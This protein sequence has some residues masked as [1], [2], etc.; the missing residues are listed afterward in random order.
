MICV[1]GLFPA[2]GARMGLHGV[3]Y[4]LAR[5]A[6]TPIASILDGRASDGAGPSGWPNPATEGV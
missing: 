6:G 4:I 5:Q 1:R 3:E 2:T